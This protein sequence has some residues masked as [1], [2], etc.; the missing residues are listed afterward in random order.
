MCDLI[1]DIISCF[2]CSCDTG[3]INVDDKIM[4]ENKKNEKI[5]KSN[6]FYIN[7][8]L[9]H[10]LGMELTVCLGELTP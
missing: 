5:W 10:C 4:I 2:V 8:Y 9:K 1:C 3:K 6:I 7:L